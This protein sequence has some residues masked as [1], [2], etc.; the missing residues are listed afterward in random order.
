GLTVQTV[1]LL[2][3]IAFRAL[4]IILAYFKESKQYIIV[5]TKD[6]K[7]LRSPWPSILVCH[8]S[9]TYFKIGLDSNHL[10]RTA[11]SLEAVVIWAG[12]FHL[13]NIDF[14]QGT[15]KTNEFFD[16]LLFKKF[17]VSGESAVRTLIKKL[18]LA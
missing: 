4:S 14:Y 6:P 15:K 13:F 16:F 8:D 7:G 12:L 18:Q 5:D 17:A 9:V 11:N 3:P 10:I 1:P 2:D